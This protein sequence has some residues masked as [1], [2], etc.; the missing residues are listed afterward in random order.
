M[1][2]LDFIKKIF[3]FQYCYPIEEPIFKDFKELKD[4]EYEIEKF[5]LLYY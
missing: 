1:N 5:Q 4:L 3:C 2:I